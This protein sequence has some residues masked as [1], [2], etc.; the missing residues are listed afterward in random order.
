MFFEVR[1]R[2]FLELRTGEALPGRWRAVPA[3]VASVLLYDDA[4]RGHA[5]GRLDGL[6]DRLPEL[7][8]TAARDGVRDAELQGLAGELLAM[9][10]HFAPHLGD[11]WVESRDVE[12]VRGYLDRYISRGRMP[13]DELAETLADDPAASLDWAAAT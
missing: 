7:W 6:R 5:L 13:A 1:A 12:S 10:V 9:A 11:G 3:V 4:A 2:G 8:R